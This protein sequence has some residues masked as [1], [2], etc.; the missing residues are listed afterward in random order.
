VPVRVF[1]DGT[2]ADRKAQLV[3][4]VADIAARVK[5]LDIARLR[6]TTT[7]MCW[8]SWCGGPRPQSHHSDFCTAAERG[9]RDSLLGRSAMPERLPQE[10]E[11]RDAAFHVILTVDNGDFVFFDCAYEELL[12]SL[13][14]IT[15]PRPCPETMFNDNVSM[16]GFDVY[17][18]LPSSSGLHAGLTRSIE[19]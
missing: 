9:A 15:T 6:T 10:R 18:Q 8:S 12:Q 7:P 17:V 5:Y 19:R 1:V 4:I 2:R 3:K 16:G 14:P 11:I 13:G